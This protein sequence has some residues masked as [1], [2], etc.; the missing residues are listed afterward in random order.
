MLEACLRPAPPRAINFYLYVVS[1]FRRT[2]HGPAKAGHYVLLE[3]ALGI[4]ARATRREGLRQ[5][6]FAPPE[7]PGRAPRPARRRAA[8]RPRHRAWSDRV[9]TRRRADSESTFPPRARAGI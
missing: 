4:T 8:R 9:P 6:R 3:N 5:D 2:S 7:S 1:A